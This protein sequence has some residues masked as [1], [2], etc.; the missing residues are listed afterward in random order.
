MKLCILQE[1]NVFTTETLW[2]KCP[3]G[4]CKTSEGWG[5]IGEGGYVGRGRALEQHVECRWALAN[6]FRYSDP[7]IAIG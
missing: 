4:M 5:W 1:E 3:K 7:Q 2:R 6:K